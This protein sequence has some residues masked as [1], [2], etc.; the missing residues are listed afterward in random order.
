MSGP[1]EDQDIRICPYCGTTYLEDSNMYEDVNRC[2]H[3]GK[4]VHKEMHES[5]D[6]EAWI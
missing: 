2:P 6:D 5:D 3:C 4:Q 1:I